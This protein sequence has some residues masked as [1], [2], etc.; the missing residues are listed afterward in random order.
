[1]KQRIQAIRQAMKTYG[2]EAMF[3]NNMANVRYLSGFTEDKATIYLSNNRACFV[4]RIGYK[5]QVER[6]H[7]DFDYLI[8]DY[9]YPTL[10]ERVAELV[11]ADKV[12]ALHFE[13][14]SL[15]WGDHQELSHC[16]KAEL[17][18]MSGV[19]E[20]VRSTK[21]ADEVQLMRTAAEITDAAFADIIKNIKPGI[22][23]LEIDAQLT[24]LIRQYGAE[25]TA[26]N[27]IIASGENIMV[28]HAAPTERRLQNGD[29]VI[30]DF[31]AKY[32]GYCMDMTRTL[33]IGKAS[34][35]Q[36]EIYNLENKAV[37]DALKVLKTGA[38]AADVAKAGKAR[39]TSA[40]YGN[41]FRHG[42]GH[43]VGVEVHESP[44]FIENSKEI[45]PENCVAT[46]EPGFYIPNI[47]GVRIEDT[48]LVTKDGAKSFLK[49]SRELIEL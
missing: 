37:D 22:S 23:E 10:G 48:F 11:A 17:V 44:K 40:G 1:M 3:I 4:I 46:L 15:S 2:I 8:Y 5:I 41:Y 45:V 24:A 35:K 31:G 20:E 47:G 38:A 43:G 42:V 19:I 34:E 9:P 26:F 36:R 49:T 30:L 16:V 29:M 27:N 12:K 25:G 21:N 14:D 7:K 33:I 32:K 18:P 6:K 13:K 28:M 39:I